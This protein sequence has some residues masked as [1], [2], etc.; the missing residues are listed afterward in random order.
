MAFQYLQGL[1]AQVNQP[2]IEAGLQ[3]D[4]SQVS[5]RPAQPGR[6]LNIDATII[7]VSAQLQSFR[8]GE[9]TMIVNGYEPTSWMSV[10]RL[11]RRGRS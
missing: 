1:A 2:V 3:I 11:R 9:V 10:P 7:Y 4:G 8:D 6:T 5:V